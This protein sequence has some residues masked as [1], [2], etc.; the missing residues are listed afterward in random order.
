MYMGVDVC[1]CVCMCIWQRRRPTSDTIISHV[2][3]LVAA[4]TAPDANT[5]MV[6]AESQM[7]QVAAASVVG[8]VKLGVMGLPVCQ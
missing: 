2:A 4:P 5:V 3:F 1:V 7:W 6:L 8:A